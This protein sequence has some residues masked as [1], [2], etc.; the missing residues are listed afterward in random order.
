MRLSNGSASSSR[1]T[2][3]HRQEFKQDKKCWRFF[4]VGELCIDQAD[5]EE[6]THQVN[7]MGHIYSGAAFVLIWLGR[8]LGGEYKPSK[9]GTSI[10]R[11]LEISSY[12]TR[13]WVVQEVM[14]AQD[15][16]MYFGLQWI[17]WSGIEGDDLPLL[18][19]ILPDSRMAQ[20]V[21]E[22]ERWDTRRSLG[23]EYPLDYL[24]ERFANQ[25]CGDP[26]DRV[27]GLLAL[28]DTFDMALGGSISAD[29]AKSAEE[30]YKDVMNSVQWSSRLRSSEAREHFEE[31]LK[32]ALSVQGSALPD[33][34]DIVDDAEHV[35]YDDWLDG[36]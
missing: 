25:E 6:K 34:E 7:L 13:L 33:F 26:R 8:D 11:R 23:F 9:T 22:K 21:A 27:Y 28:V 31:V 32:N 5:N 17:D 3:Q 4:W 18:R 30:V 35:N 29:Y 20:L 24:I 12:W 14:L 19:Y 16:L 36:T 2:I 15:I 1:W 10:L